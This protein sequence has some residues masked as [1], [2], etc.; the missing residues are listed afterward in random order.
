MACTLLWDKDEETPTMLCRETQHC[1]P[2]FSGA[3][4]TVCMTARVKSHDARYM[5]GQTQTHAH[6]S[7]A[8]RSACTEAEGVEVVRE[9]EGVY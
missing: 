1:P 7:L 2:I 9:C 4:H 8:H 3:F 6:S 5:G